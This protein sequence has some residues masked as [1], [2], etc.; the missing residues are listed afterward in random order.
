MIFK[1]KKRR[2]KEVFFCPPP[3]ADAAAFRTV[4]AVSIAGEGIASRV[5][6]KKKKKKKVG[7]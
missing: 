7:R 5:E 2:E 6:K 1:A 3:P 4:F